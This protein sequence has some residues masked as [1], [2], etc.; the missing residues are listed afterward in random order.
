[1]A[2]KAIKVYLSE[3][4]A[5]YANTYPIRDTVGG[6]ASFY[7]DWAFKQ[8]RRGRNSSLKQ[9]SDEEKR[10]I[11]ACAKFL[12]ITPD[13]TPMM[14]AAAIND[15][16]ADD[17]RAAEFCWGSDDEILILIHKCRD[18]TPAEVIGLLSWAKGNEN[19]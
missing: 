11:R 13:Y 2:K 14:F 7:V 10:A 18:M 6:T 3:E 16:F 17:P 19:S 5:A 8:V 12:P 1:M 9:L 15:W 4:D